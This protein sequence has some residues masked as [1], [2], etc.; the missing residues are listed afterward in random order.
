L[1]GTFDKRNLVREYYSGQK[2]ILEIGCSV[3]NVSAAFVNYPNINFLGID[4]DKKAISYAKKRFHHLKN[5]SFENYDLHELIKTK[6]TFDY[7]LFAG[8]L[9]HVDDVVAKELLKSAANLLEP[10][11]I[12]VIS[13]PLPSHND[14]KW[15]I[16]FYHNIFEQGSWVREKNDL[17]KII[18]AT[19]CLQIKSSEVKCI[20][21][22]LFKWPTHGHFC[23][24][25]AS[26]KHSN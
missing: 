1:G 21:P 23:L 10:E 26:A 16:R 2:R 17:E 25:V 11:G 6:R 13:E 20:S 8:V 18:H 12:M 14:D 4:I 19:Q 5:F 3:G 15:L 7:I 22:F 9:H 24:L